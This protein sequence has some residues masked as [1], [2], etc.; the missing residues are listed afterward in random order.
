MSTKIQHAAAELVSSIRAQFP[1]VAIR[2][3]AKIA[4]VEEAVE[5]FAALGEPKPDEPAESAE[6]DAQPAPAAK[7]T[8]AKPAKA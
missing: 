4:A 1:H 2:L 5:Q 7:K 3:E 6:R 8:A